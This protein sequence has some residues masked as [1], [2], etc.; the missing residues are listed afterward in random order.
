MRTQHIDLK[1]N[2]RHAFTLVELLVVIGII[3]LLISI[4][5]PS[6]N[7]ARREAQRTAC[8]SNMRQLIAGVIMFSNDHK[9]YLLKRKFNAG[10]SVD[11]TTGRVLSGDNWGFNDPNGEWDFVLNTLYI[12][13][14]NCFRCPTDGSV[15]VRGSD[16]AQAMTPQNDCFPVSYRLNC[17]NIPHDLAVPQVER[18]IKINQ[19]HP[20]TRSMYICEGTDY[21]QPPQAFPY[22][23]VATWDTGYSNAVY[24]AQTDAR[25]VAYNR[26]GTAA[27]NFKDPAGVA[28]NEPR[29]KSTRANYAFLDGH[30]ETLSWA[31]TWQ[32]YGSGPGSGGGG[33]FGGL[34]NG[35]QGQPTMWR[36][37]FD[38]T[39]EPDH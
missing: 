14:K 9:G 10:A 39:T 29:A 15:A 3:A 20:I 36:Q 28:L 6:L 19:L 16:Y 23:H 24:V 4:L 30:V 7:K 26:H 2:R 37:R 21:Q 11:P 5:L 22:H 1:R 18:D 25:N 32:A 34:S 27:Y 33:P 31:E 17:S 38:P 12:K 13:N 8:Q 35:A